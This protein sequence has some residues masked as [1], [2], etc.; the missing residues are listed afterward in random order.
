MTDSHALTKRADSHACTGRSPAVPAKIRAAVELLLEL[1]GPPDY[2]K[3][4]KQVG[5]C[6]AAELRRWLNKPQSIRYLRNRKQE[7]LEAINAANPEALRR[8]RDESGNSMAKVQAVRALESMGEQMEHQ[9]GAPSGQVAAGFVI[10]IAHRDGSEQVIAPPLPALPDG[11][12]IDLEPVDDA[13]DRGG[14][15]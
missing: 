5:Y 14:E 8:V 6:S 15:R 13:D 3:L 12:V 9:A 10:L 4:A 7:R 1:A 11:S 2:A